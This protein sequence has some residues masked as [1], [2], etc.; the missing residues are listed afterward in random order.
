MGTGKNKS[1]LGTRVAE[2]C[3]SVLSPSWAEVQ[4]E[5]RTRAW[6]GTNLGVGIEVFATRI[7]AQPSGPRGT[8][9]WR[10]H[11]RQTQQ[12]PQI[13]KPRLRASAHPWA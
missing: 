4:L 13:A 1:R 10:D 7:S 6:S 2:G 12:P 5:A 3:V 9:A 11:N 8:H